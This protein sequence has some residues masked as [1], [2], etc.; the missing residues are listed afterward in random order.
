M[1]AVP[2]RSRASGAARDMAEPKGAVGAVAGDGAAEGGADE[3]DN[4]GGSFS[5]DSHGTAPVATP[6]PATAT[7]GVKTAA[8]IEEDAHAKA[9][10][11]PRTTRRKRRPVSPDSAR[12]RK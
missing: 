6:P 10:T 4:D 3:I 11:P 12:R 2:G 8:E 7:R 5:S 1:A 9:S